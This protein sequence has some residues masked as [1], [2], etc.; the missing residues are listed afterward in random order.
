MASLCPLSR[1]GRATSVTLRLPASI[2]RPIGTRHL[3]VALHLGRRA[4]GEDAVVVEADDAVGHAI[5]I[6]MSCSTKS[7]VMP[8]LRMRASSG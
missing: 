5:T 7:T 3:Q 1:R 4:R 6:F 8:S 2:A